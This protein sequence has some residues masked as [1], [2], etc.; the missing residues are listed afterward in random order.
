MEFIFWSFGILGFIYVI[1]SNFAIIV[2]KR[3]GYKKSFLVDRKL[4]SDF[5][6]FTKSNPGYKFLYYILVFSTLLMLSSF[7]LF[8]IFMFF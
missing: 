3:N 8:I 5:K 4:Y 7:S 6:E 2:L 1:A